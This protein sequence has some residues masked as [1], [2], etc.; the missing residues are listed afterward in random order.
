MTVTDTSIIIILEGP[1]TPTHTP[2]HTHT[3]THTHTIV[4]KL[5]KDR[6]CLNITAFKDGLQ[7]SQFLLEQV[8]SCLEPRFLGVKTQ[9]GNS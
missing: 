3:H 4:Y 8:N 1:S 5:Y 9:N 7:R 2:T 6:C